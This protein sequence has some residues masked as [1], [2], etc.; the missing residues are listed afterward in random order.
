MLA[1]TTLLG[2]TNPACLAGLAASWH[3]GFWLAGRLCHVLGMP[4]CCSLRPLLQ[5][6]YML[7]ALQCLS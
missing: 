5:Q 7:C 6:G 3:D 4:A 2:S 1:T